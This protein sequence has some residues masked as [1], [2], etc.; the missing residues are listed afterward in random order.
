MTILD[1]E[2]RATG[3]KLPDLLREI[4]EVGSI[5]IRLSPFLFH[6]FTFILL[7]SLTDLLRE[8]DEVGFI[9][10][11]DHAVFFNEILSHFKYGS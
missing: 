8:I 3:P 1:R 9:L 6:T 11:S 4:V 2:R 7:L 5:L 10:I